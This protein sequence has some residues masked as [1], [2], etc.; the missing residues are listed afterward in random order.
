MY[1]QRFYADE[2]NRN[3]PLQELH[4]VFIPHITMPQ[5]SNR[6][7]EKKAGIV[8][9]GIRDTCQAC[10]YKKGTEKEDIERAKKTNK[11]LLYTGGYRD[12]FLA[13]VFQGNEY[14]EYDVNASIYRITLLIKN[15][16][17][18]KTAGK[19]LYNSFLGMDCGEFRSFVKLLAMIIYFQSDRTVREIAN[20]D[21]AR[22]VF[23]KNVTFMERVEFVSVMKE[24]MQRILGDSL[25]SEVFLHESCIY[26]RFNYELQKLGY[27]V[28]QIYDGFYTDAPKDFNFEALLIKVAEWYYQA[29][30]KDEKADYYK[31]SA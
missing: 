23:G 17:W 4:K 15:G 6:K 3:E 22:K 2:L 25:G 28:V 27:R 16:I 8:R 9:L 13:K 5:N 31:L 19:D 7:H 30:I 24:N 21:S 12:D 14:T 26:M 20:S 11:P 1:F 29:F 18:P 10:S